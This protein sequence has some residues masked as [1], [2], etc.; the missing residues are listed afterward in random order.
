MTAFNIHPN[1]LSSITC[2]IAGEKDAG[3]Y[4]TNY[5]VEPNTI[6]MNESDRMEVLYSGN[7]VIGAVE[8][9]GFPLVPVRFSIW[10]V[11]ATQAAA[12]ASARAIRQAFMDEAGGYIEYRP[13]GLSSS[14]LTTWYR[15]LMSVPP[16]LVDGGV[17][18]TKHFMEHF[19]IVNS[20]QKYVIRLDCQDVMT[21]AW[22]T[23]DPDTLQAV[24]TATTLDGVDDGDDNNSVNILSSAI[25]GDI[26][27]P[28]IKI[29]NAADIRGLLIH[30]RS[31][32]SATTAQDIFEAE[33]QTLS[34]FSSQAA[35]TASNG[36]VARSTSTPASVN[37]SIGTG[38]DSYC[39]G[40]ISPIIVASASDGTTEWEIQLN[41]GFGALGV[42]WIDG[43]T[44]TVD[45]T[46]R[47]IE[48][49]FNDIDI[50]PANIPSYVSDDSSP[51][52]AQFVADTKLFFTCTRTVGSGTLDIDYILLAKADD[53]FVAW[54]EYNQLELGANY[55]LDIDMLNQSCYLRYTA[56]NDRVADIWSKYGT[57]YAGLAMRAGLNHRLRVMGAAGGIWLHDADITCRVTVQGIFGTI[58]PFDTA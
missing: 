36:N 1:R 25:K 2:E 21:Y 29:D 3:Q 54:L 16:H 38:W 35:A 11:G 5:I 58:Y 4:T 48:I 49:G 40:K 12:M 39:V 37:F 20:N 41:V 13:L 57:P 31:Y 6:D 22:P 26:L 23:S 27:F 32:L 45:H 17:S 53:A 18:L 43:G 14:V 24:K 56:A 30:R 7:R 9:I 33:S 19:G 42:V 8:N 44:I 10:I 15:Y 52:L 51:T 34:N 55:R 50:P 47:R 46:T 28:V